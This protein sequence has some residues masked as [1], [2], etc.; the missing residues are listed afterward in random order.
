MVDPLGGCPFVETLTDEIEARI[1]ELMDEVAALGGAV[2]ALEQGFQRGVIDD[3]AY[4]YQR[5]VESGDHVVVG[6]N[7]F[8]GD[9]EV[10]DHAPSPER[11]DPALEEEHRSAL[12]AWKSSRN[13]EPV[14]SSLS[15]LERA[16][17]GTDNVMPHVLAASEAGATL[18]QI[19]S[20]FASVFGEYNG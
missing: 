11:I 14:M 19:S 6:V 12:L 17:K 16:A 8:T 13:L 10:S 20:T 9:N 7:A 15:R 18:G 5:N 1:V 4:R 3:E 2:A